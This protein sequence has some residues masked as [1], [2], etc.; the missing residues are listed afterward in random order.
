MIARCYHI[1]HKGYKNYGG[2]GISV[3]DE[4]RGSNGFENF[5]KWSLENGF[6]EE[7]QLDRIDNNGNYEPSNCRWVDGKT[8]MRNRRNNVKINGKTLI[9]IANDTGMKY[10]AL[11]SRYK[12][13]GDIVLK[14]KKCA[15]C[16]KKFMPQNFNQ[17]FCSQECKNMKYNMKIE[18]LLK[19]LRLE[20]NITLEELAK[21]SGISKSHLSRIERNEKQ[22]T[23]LV[24]V[25]IAKA[26]DIELEEL[27]K[28]YSEE[29]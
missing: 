15:W 7:L 13:C 10:S 1:S 24:A 26:L 28:I 22:P 8:N 20:R 4:W 19:E 11:N 27:Y 18:I 16:N 12:A 9:E 25:K 29:R 17:Q 23:I 3:C 6:K 2:R 21:I 14:E 5:L